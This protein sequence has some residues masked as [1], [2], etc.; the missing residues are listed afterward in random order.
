VERPDGHTHRI[1]GLADVWRDVRM[2]D[3]E[4]LAGVVRD[5]RIDILVDLTMHMASGRPLLFARKPA[6]IAIAWLAYPGTTGSGAIDYRFTDP[7]LDPDGFEDQYSERS[8]RLPDSFWCYDPLADQP[9]VNALPALERGH[10]T[11][12]CLNNP[13]KVTE[14]TLH[15]WG[16][17]MRALPDSR[18]R[19]LA[20]PGRARCRLLQRLAAHGIAAERISFVGF[21]PRADYLRCYHDIDIG[22][23]TFPYNGHTTSLDSLWMGV[24]TITRVGETCVGRGGLS[25]LFQLGLVELAAAGDAAFTA[26]A[27]RLAADLP[28]LAELRQALRARLER[29]PLMD[30]GRFARNIEAAYRGVWRDYCGA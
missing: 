16:G 27:A 13:C 5:D 6:P 23:D 30:A 25:Q 28:G 8:I 10:L 24:P 17:V 15:L 12:G 11:F 7:R 18:L 21:R 9:E 19:L 2:L 26:A 1:A 3:D 14:S 4:A 29:S 20:P 22:L